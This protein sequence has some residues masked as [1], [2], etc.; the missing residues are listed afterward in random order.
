MLAV[1]AQMQVGNTAE[2]VEVT[3]Q[4]SLLKTETPEVGTVLGSKHG[5]RS[6]AR[7]FRRP[8]C[9]K[10]RIQADTG[11]GGDNWESH[12][13]GAPSFSKEVVLDGA[14]ATIYIS[15]H[16]GESSPSMEALEEFKVQTSGMSAEYTRTSGGFSTS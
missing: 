13:N 6:A 4:A 11:V 14:S 2:T 15:G 10:L 8:L 3:A 12:I 7:A 16:M 9:R 1:D 5:H